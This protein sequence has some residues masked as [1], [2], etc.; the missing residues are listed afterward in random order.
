MTN[1]DQPSLIIF[2]FLLVSV[3]FGLEQSEGKF[4]KKLN[5]ASNQEFAGDCI[6]GARKPLTSISCVLTLHFKGASAP[7]RKF[8]K[9]D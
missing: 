4:T 9:L 7:L 5:E 8:Y 2:T 3:L 6:A 1:F